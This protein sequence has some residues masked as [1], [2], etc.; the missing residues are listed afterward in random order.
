MKDSI[1]IRLLK[2]VQNPYVQGMCIERRP[3]MD[4]S[5]DKGFKDNI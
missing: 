1:K 3:L 4:S 5:Q 2:L